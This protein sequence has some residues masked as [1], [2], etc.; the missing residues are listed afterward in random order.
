MRVKAEKTYKRTKKNEEEE[1]FEDNKISEDEW[2][3]DSLFPL[4][5]DAVQILKRNLFC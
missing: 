3:S 2:T 4:C 1:F 5:S